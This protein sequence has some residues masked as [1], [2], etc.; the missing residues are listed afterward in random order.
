MPEVGG[1]QTGGG[2]H[3]ELAPASG[4]SARRS[5]HTVSRSLYL[6]NTDGNEVE[7]CLGD[8]DAD[9]RNR[10][11]WTEKPVHPLRL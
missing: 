5:D 10:D 9:R 3:R 8:L 2:E 4:E 11:G 1:E 7:L 6:R